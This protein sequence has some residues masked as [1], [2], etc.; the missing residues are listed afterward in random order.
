MVAAETEI[1]GDGVPADPL[2]PGV[3]ADGRELHSKPDEV[4]E[5][6]GRRGV[7]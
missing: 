7:D 3:E 6:L 4:I 5:H 2:G 1:P